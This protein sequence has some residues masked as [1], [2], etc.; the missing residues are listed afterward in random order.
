MIR[1]RF[2]PSPTGY[3]HLGNIRTALFNYLFA[4]ANH[5]TFLF[6]VE[7]TDT[8]RSKKEFLESQKEDLRWLGLEWDEGPDVGGE[9]GPYLQ[10]ERLDLYRREIQRLMAED[11]AYACYVSESE[12]EE[13]KKTAAAEKRP[14]HFDNRGRHFS[15]EEIA[16][17][18]QQWIKPTVRFKIDQPELKMHDLIRGEVSVNLDDMIGDFVIQRADGMPT[19]HLAVVVDDA[20]MKVTHVIR[21]E[22]HL[23]NTPKH[24]LLQRALGYPTPEYAHLSLVTGPGGEPLSKRLSAVSVREF[25]KSG[26]LPQALANY[27]ALLGWAPPDAK[28]EILPWKELIQ[29]FDLKKVS[30]SSSCFDPDKLNWVNGEHL[31][32]LSSQDFVSRAMAYLKNQNYSSLSE[33]EL[34]KILPIYQD[35]IQ[36]FD[37]LP[38]RLEIWQDK[39]NY[40]DMQLIKLESSKKML[41][42]AL[43]LAKSSEGV[44]KSYQEF[45]DQLKGKVTLKGKDFF[46]VLRMAL[47]GKFNGPE[48]KRIY[49]V[50]GT[51]GVKK[52]LEQALAL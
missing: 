41:E 40:E 52:R 32:L 2:A 34:R 14:I 28:R 29:S 39:L 8:E 47:S 33:N 49:A 43:N 10:S 3:L 23:S 38:I 21:G 25:R 12:I 48:I 26:Y 27:I 19:F 20:M 46:H 45:V 42:E 13:M 31:R 16:K 35:N 1:V 51:S 17:R 4:K 6:R 9:F 7:D 36:K 50:L 15:K 22:D 44:E 18:V 5:G 30:K 11:K 37:D 24:I